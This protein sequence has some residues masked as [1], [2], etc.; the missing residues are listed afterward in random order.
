MRPVVSDSGA[1]GL[2]LLVQARS[3]GQPFRLVLLDEQ[4]PA[5]DGLEFI[6]R[7]RADASLKDTAIVMLTSADQ[8]ASAARCRHQ[9]VAVYLTKPVRIA[10][11][12]V[13]IQKVL[14]TRQPQPARRPPGFETKPADHSMRILIAEDNRINRRLAVA[15]LEKLGHQVAV[16]TN[17]VEALEAW[18]SSDFDL[19]F[20]DVQMPELDGFETTQ[21]I[22][23]EETSSG[24]HVHIVAM[25][26]NA[27]AGDSELCLAAGM[28]D[29]LSKPISRQALEL[30]IRNCSLSS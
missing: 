11:L 16:A 12:F 15:M 22:R 14:G 25:T 20:M 18:R 27:M 24:K 28:D 7:I 13:S 9:G 2:D 21:R 17:G 10:E 19:I 8:G 23:S 1:S 6:D 3:S 29:Y 4:M 26:A 5:M 30:S